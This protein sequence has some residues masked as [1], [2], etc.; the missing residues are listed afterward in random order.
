MLVMALPISL[1]GL[2]HAR[3]WRGGGILYGIAT[4]LL[5]AAMVSTFRK[6][7]FMAPISVVSHAGL[8]PPPRAPPCVWRRSRSPLIVTDP[9][10]G[11]GARSGRSRS[12]CVATGSASTR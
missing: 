12:S 11:P 1:V 8:L 6:S 2:I 9:R 7:A 3:A 4:A 10:A 5:F